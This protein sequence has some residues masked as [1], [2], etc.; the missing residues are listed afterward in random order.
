M[1]AC[2]NNLLVCS[3]L[4][5]VYNTWWTLHPDKG[6]NIMVLSLHSVNFPRI[7][8]HFFFFEIKRKKEK[9]GE[10]ASYHLLNVIEIGQLGKVLHLW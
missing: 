5:L 9:K 1:L 7:E 6:E 3:H 2:E 8:T 10:Q 4:L